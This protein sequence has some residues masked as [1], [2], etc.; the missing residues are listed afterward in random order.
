MK[1]KEKNMRQYHHRNIKIN[2]FFGRNTSI[3]SYIY[4]IICL[5]YIFRH[6][7]Y[8]HTIIFI[9]ILRIVVLL[10]FADNPTAQLYKET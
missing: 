1:K 3:C 9:C 8:Y 7:V 10:A 2:R 5:K 6:C 4:F